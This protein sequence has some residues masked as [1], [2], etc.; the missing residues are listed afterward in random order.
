MNAPFQCTKAFDASDIKRADVTQSNQNVLDLLDS[1]EYGTNRR[2]IFAN[3]FLEK[4][5]TSID[6][7]FVKAMADFLTNARVN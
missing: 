6:F 1:T 2:W 7:Q 3:R 4:E 5:L